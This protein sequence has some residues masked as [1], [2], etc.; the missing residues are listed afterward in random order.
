[1]YVNDIKYVHLLHFILKKLTIV[2]DTRKL[3][4]IVVYYV[5]YYNIDFNNI[6]IIKESF[7][8]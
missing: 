1:M 5:K 8:T 6:L 7:F 4:V 3:I 2:I